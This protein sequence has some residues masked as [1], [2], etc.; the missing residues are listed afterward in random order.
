[1]DTLRLSGNVNNI[2]ELRR[3]AKDLQKNGLPYM[4]SSVIVWGLVLGVQIFATSV[5]NANLLTFISSA[6]MMP[7]A[8]L[9]SRILKANIF[10]KTKN[11]VSKLG[12]LCTMNQNLYLPI[13][14]LAC[15]FLPQAMLLMYAII[16][17]AHL[18]PF[19]WVYNCK[20][21][22]V[23]SIIEAVGAM[24][25]SIL[26]GNI[27]IAAFIIIMQIILVVLLFINARKEKIL[28]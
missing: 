27:G 20:A 19:A 26:F 17:G 3:E 13:A 14:M 10:K 24:F 11:P 28:N 12:F 7:I 4:M 25:A 23:I 16:F 6:F 8:I 1:M 5:A 18:L 15:T 21:Y 2:D 22:T 9:F